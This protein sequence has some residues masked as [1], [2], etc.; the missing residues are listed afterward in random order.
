MRVYG[1]FLPYACE[2]LPQGDCPPAVADRPYEDLRMFKG[3]AVCSG[4]AREGTLT[5]EGA[6]GSAMTESV[7]GQDLR[8][9]LD[10]VNAGYQDEPTEGLPSAVLEGL[11][12]LVPCDSVSFF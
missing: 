7:T 12:Q 6:G 11:R 4:A 10:T 3:S 5:V 8:A 1:C 9:M 2:L